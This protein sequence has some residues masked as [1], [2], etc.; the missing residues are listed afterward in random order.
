MFSR[1]TG[2]VWIGIII[3]SGMFLM[4][5]QTWPPPVTQA[6]LTIFPSSGS[7]SVGDTFSVDILID[8]HGESVLVASAYVKYDP[9]S[10]KINT[11]DST[12][13]VFTSGVENIIDSANGLLRIGMSAPTPGIITASGKVA[14][15][16]F[17]ALAPTNPTADNVVFDFTPGSTN[18]SYVGRDDELGTGILT[19]VNNARFTVN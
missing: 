11:I 7:Y 10:F 6:T 8:T 17:T 3:L 4:G 12:G 19:G 1:R 13:S 18:R 15:I 5:Q 16:S 2:P 14:S 9:T